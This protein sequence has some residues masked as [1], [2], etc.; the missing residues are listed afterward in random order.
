MVV[1]PALGRFDSLADARDRISG[2][3][4]SLRIRVSQRPPL[5]ATENL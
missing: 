3:V 5:V 1:F 2:V 4:Y